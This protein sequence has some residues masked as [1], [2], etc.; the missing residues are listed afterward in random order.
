MLVDCMSDR[1]HY[2]MLF[3]NT[4]VILCIYNFKVHL[5]LLITD[6]VRNL[7]KFI[8]IKVAQIVFKFFL[9]PTHKVMSSKKIQVVQTLEYQRIC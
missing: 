4:H 2:I 7:L 8:K 6:Q 1:K 3:K 5:Y 9:N